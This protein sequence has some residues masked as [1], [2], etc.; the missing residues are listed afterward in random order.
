MAMTDD[1][2]AIVDAMTKFG[3]SFVK[4][5]AEL[6][7]VADS[8]NLAIIKA[9]WCVDWARYERMALGTIA[10]GSDGANGTG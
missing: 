2:R 6:C 10:K 4:R 1:D 3:G 7:R 5:L 8:N 9:V